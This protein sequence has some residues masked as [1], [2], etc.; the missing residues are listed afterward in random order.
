MSPTQ[1]LHQEYLVLAR[2]RTHRDA[3]A[4]KSRPERIEGA[5]KTL[6]QLL[7]DAAKEVIIAGQ[8]FGFFE[9][10]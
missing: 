2:D 8:C 6:R 1:W 10:L 9:R 4:D 3:L 7:D 5:K